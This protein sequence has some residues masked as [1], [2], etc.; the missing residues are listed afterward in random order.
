MDGREGLRQECR[1]ETQIDV[2]GL[3]NGTRH[4]HQCSVL[5]RVCLFNGTILPAAAGGQ[6]EQRAK[7]LATTLTVRSMFGSHQT[8]KLGYLH[9]M[10]APTPH[11]LAAKSIRRAVNR[12]GFSRCVPLIWV[13][14]WQLA[15][16]WPV[17]GE[18]PTS[19]GPHWSL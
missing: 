3:L 17:L 8:F 15:R 7:H 19:I 16:Q 14:A 5:N 12:E 2:P 4:R 11:S 1:A 13:P 18:T 6:A 9:P 10:N